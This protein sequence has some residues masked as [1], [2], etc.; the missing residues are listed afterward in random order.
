MSSLSSQN[1]DPSLLCLLRSRSR[2]TR[3]RSSGIRTSSMDQAELSTEQVLQRD[4]PWETYMT[5]KLISA[6]DLQLL[7]RYDKKTESARAQLLDEFG[8]SYVQLF[9]TILRDIFKEET[10]EYVLALIYEMLSA[11]PARA[12][13]FHDQSLA[14]EDTYE[15]FLRAIGSFK[16][17]S[18]K[19]LAWIISYRPKAS[20]IANG[21]A[22]GS[23]K[24]ITTID[25]LLSGLVEWLCAQLRQPSHP[26]RGAPVAISC[27]S[28]LLKEPVVRSLFVQADGVKLLVPLISPASTQQSIQLL[29]ETCLCIWLMSYYEP[30]IEYL[31]TSRTMLR[32]TEVV[33]SSTKEK[34][35]DLGLPHIIHSLKTQA[36]SDEDL[37]DALNQLEED[38]KD[39][40]RKLSSFDKYKQEVLLGHLDWNP[41]HK[42]ANFWRENV[43]SFEENDLQI[44][45][46]LL[47]ILDTSSDPRSL[48]V[49]CY[50]LSQFIQYHAAGRVIVTD[51][52]AKERVM[53]LMAHENAEVTKNALLCIQRLLLGA[54][55]ASFLQV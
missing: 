23:K 18:R 48:A 25:D 30:T 44:L 41:M 4:I 3:L 5:T 47:T 55:Y 52:K 16:K 14:H 43:T 2:S 12:R 36:W 40:I 37:L 9:V 50:D 15:P 31:A 53:K 24:H 1:R 42:E 13:L 34:M 21:E 51:L 38:L 27:L 54:K 8:F 20:V 35:V 19:I 45:R 33:K 32:L 28:T 26:T 22:S 6:T 17:K 7:R 49:A 39:K 11:N 46:V 10:V 29:Y